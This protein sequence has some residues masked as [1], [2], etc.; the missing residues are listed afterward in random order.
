MHERVLI[1]CDCGARCF[2]ETA[3]L[4]HRAV[5]PEHKPRDEQPITTENNGNA[6]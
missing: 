2:G 1:V 3:W 5:N 6:K 4:L